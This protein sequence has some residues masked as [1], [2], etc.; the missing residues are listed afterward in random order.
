MENENQWGM[1]YTPIKLIITNQ[2][3]V[4]FDKNWKPIPN[5]ESQF[6]EGYEAALGLHMLKGVN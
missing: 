6:I 5:F 1:Y 4:A 2:E 3:L